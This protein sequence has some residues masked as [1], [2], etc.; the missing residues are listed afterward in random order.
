MKE[1][2]IYSGWQFPSCCRTFVL[3]VLWLESSGA[4]R[5]FQTDRN[6]AEYNKLTS[7]CRAPK[8]HFLRRQR[9]NMSENSSV[10]HVVQLQTSHI[11]SLQ[12][13]VCMVSL[14]FQVM[15]FSLFCL[16]NIIENMFL[17]YRPIQGKTTELDLCRH[18]LKTPGCSSEQQTWQT[19][20]Q[21]R[22]EHTFCWN[23]LLLCGGLCHLLWPAGVADRIKIIRRRLS[24]GQMRW[25]SGR[26]GTVAEQLLQGDHLQAVLPA[27]Q[28][29][30]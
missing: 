7:D 23:L 6:E 27:A 4:A 14:N 25:E 15:H 21:G 29:F 18:T 24:S 16:S 17:F 10:W 22:R 26:H 8:V 12:T 1:A 11:H 19:C 30:H 9:V 20:F 5:Y 28:S 13:H 2:C 3:F